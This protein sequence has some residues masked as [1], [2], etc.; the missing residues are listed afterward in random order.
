MG[1]VTLSR[2][3]ARRLAFLNGAARCA[4][5]LAALAAPT[6]PLAPWVG[7]ARSAPAVRLLARALGARDLALG[8]GA[9]LALSGDGPVRGWMEAAALADAGDVLVTLGTSAIGPRRGRLA[10]LA[11]AAGGATCAGLA[12]RHV[13]QPAAGT[14][15]R[16]LRADQITRIG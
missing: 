3:R 16:P 13:D 7:E 2:D 5:G 4:L 9:L 15:A 10:V 12:A 11:A 14:A 8:L 6:V 1:T